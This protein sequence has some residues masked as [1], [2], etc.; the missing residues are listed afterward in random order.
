MFKW[1]RKQW[2][3]ASIPPR[4]LHAKGTRLLIGYTTD[5]KNI[6]CGRFNN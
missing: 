1:R 5:L 3:T 6:I 4:S 2:E